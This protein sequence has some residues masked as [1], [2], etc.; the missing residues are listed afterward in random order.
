MA[1]GSAAVGV[2]GD[3]GG[4]LATYNAFYEQSIPFYFM[5]PVWFAA[6]ATGAESDAEAT[7]LFF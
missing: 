4:G 5:R 2:I 1:V 3:S 7:P 6:Y